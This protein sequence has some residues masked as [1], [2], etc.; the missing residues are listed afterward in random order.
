MR[1]IRFSQKGLLFAALSFCFYAAGAS[2]ETT[3]MK[4][5]KGY[6]LSILPAMGAEKVEH[7]PRE[8]KG[9]VRI[10]TLKETVYGKAEAPKQ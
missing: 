1:H 3:L 4:T 9:K 10:E 2:G 8:A 7:K 6:R 5:S